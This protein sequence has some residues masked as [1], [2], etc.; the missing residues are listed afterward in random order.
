[1]VLIVL[2]CDYHASNIFIG[3]G[4]FIGSAAD[5]W[6]ARTTTDDATNNVV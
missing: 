6:P 5:K 1:M 3:S 2:S 4:L